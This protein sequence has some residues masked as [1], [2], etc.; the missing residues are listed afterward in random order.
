MLVGEKRPWVEIDLS[1]WFESKAQSA[2]LF[3]EKRKPQFNKRCS[4]PDYLFS[5]TVLCTF[6]FLL[7][8][9]SINRLVL[10]TFVIQSFKNLTENALV[11]KAGL[12]DTE[13]SIL[14]I[15]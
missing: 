2:V 1:K 14:F 8:S 13:G 6:D 11:F 9:G 12:Y 10:C 4:A 5:S 15:P 3:I 7:S